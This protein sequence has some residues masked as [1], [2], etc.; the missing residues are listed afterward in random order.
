[1]AEVPTEIVKLLME[2]GYIAGGQGLF[3][4]SRAIFEAVKAARE[5][6]EY[7][8]IGMAVTEL[9]AGEY[10]RALELLEEAEQLNAE[11]Y[12]TKSFKGLTYKLIGEITKAKEVL[13]EVVANAKEEEA[14]NMARAL[15]KEI[16]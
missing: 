7:P 12:L 15:L 8:L 16:S 3:K 9:N 14:L 4:E 6:S 11:N 13:K 1:M 5:D 10:N 2:I